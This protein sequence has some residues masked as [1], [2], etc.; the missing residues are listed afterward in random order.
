MAAG[1]GIDGKG[2]G[3]LQSNPA[4][5]RCGLAAGAGHPW[6]CFV[7]ETDWHS[8]ASG[9]GRQAAGASWPASPER[10]QRAE[11]RAED[12]RKRVCRPSH[13]CPVAAGTQRALGGT[14]P[15]ARRSRAPAPTCCAPGLASDTAQSP[16]VSVR[17]GCCQAPRAPS[18]QEGATLVAGHPPPP[19]PACQLPT[20]KPSLP[21]VFPGSLRAPACP[22]AARSQ[23]SV[24]STR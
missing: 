15:P 22:P 14:W 12:P 6:G 23:S 13:R 24:S 8:L 11:V 19:L 17:A 18:P 2:G 20:S 5:G 4:G 1:V 10:S 9:G 7:Q 21:A 3:C 16:C